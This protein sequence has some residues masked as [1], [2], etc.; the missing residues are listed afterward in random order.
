MDPEA[1]KRVLRKLTY[2]LYV[3]TAKGAEGPAAGTMNFVTQTSLDPPL[4]VVGM[5]VGSRIAEAAEASGHFAVNIVGRDQ[6]DTASAFFKAARQ[7]GDK[8]N[9][10]EFVPGENGS[11][12][13]P[14]VP[15]AFE[16]KVEQIAELGDHNIVVGRITCVHEHND[17]AP[18]TMADTDWSYG[19]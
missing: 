11:P 12:I 17:I 18:L 15:A 2:G 7:E 13:L 10:V 3:V 14:G 8:I 16:C 5:R 4:V 6:H 1:R 9:G 19:G